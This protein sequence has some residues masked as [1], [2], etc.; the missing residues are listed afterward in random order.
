M[1]LDKLSLRQVSMAIPVVAFFNWVALQFALVPQM[2][3]SDRENL[4]PRWL[5]TPYPY[6]ISVIFMGFAIWL[7]FSYRGRLATHGLKLTVYALAL[8][9]LCGLAVILAIRI[10]WGV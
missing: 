10:T 5:A 8:A 2:A 7:A 3:E 9:V 6:V 1:R 4:Y